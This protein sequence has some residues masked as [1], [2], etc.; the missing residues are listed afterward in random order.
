MAG[1]AA[2]PRFFLGSETYPLPTCN[3]QGSLEPQPPT[4]TYSLAPEHMPIS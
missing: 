1:S 2:T 4:S 3:T